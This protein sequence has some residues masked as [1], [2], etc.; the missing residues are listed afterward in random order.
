YET[1]HVRLRVYA[2]T[3][4]LVA[5]LVNERRPA[6]IHTVIWGGSR[7]GNGVYVCAL[8]AGNQREVRKL[9]LLK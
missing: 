6:G 1:Q 7:Y 9:T 2:I 5:E 8:E 4:S 3:G